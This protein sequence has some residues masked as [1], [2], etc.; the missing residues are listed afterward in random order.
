MST[1]SSGYYTLEYISVFYHCCYC[2][3]EVS[4]VSHLF[5]TLCM[6]R[7]KAQKEL[8]LALDRRYSAYLL[9]NSMS[10]SC[11]LR[12]SPADSRCLKHNHIKDHI[13]MDQ[14]QVFE[15]PLQ[16]SANVLLVFTYWFY[17]LLVQ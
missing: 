15:A 4:E 10:P 17:I 16:L 12:S 5:L 13:S 9:E 11:L 3:S 2:V 14:H 6:R 8:C 1:N 7:R